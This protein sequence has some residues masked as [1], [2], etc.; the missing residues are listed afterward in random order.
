MMSLPNSEYTKTY[1]HPKLPDDFY[2]LYFK[3]R[4][5]SREGTVTSTKVSC[6]CDEATATCRGM[7]VEMETGVIMAASRR[8]RTTDC[9]GG[10]DPTTRPDGEGIFQSITLVV[11][12]YHYLG[13]QQC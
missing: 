6:S 7:D 5:G 9:G 4:T 13:V 10:R 11:R 3:S 2:K 8:R 12:R 1:I